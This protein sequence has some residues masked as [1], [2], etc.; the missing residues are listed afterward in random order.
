[1]QVEVRFA[2]L[3]RRYVGEQE[4]VFDVPDGSTAGDLLLL[5]GK[6]YGPRLPK[7]LWDEQSGRFHRSIR[8]ARS[9]SPR[10]DET[11]LLRDGDNILL[12][13]ALAG[14]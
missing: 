7:N 10:L 5:I 14:G 1:M 8:I 12:I 6:E 13:F 2:G 4:K 3:F 11:E 9:G